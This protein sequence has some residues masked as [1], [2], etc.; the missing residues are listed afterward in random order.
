MPKKDHRVELTDTKV[1]ALKPAPKGSRYQVMD[2]LVPGFGLRITDTGA[3]TFILRT[4][5]PGG[6][7]TASRR[8]I[9]RVGVMTLADARDKARAWQALV[10]RGIDPSLEEEKQRA[11]EVEKRAN[12][13][14][15][16]AEDFIAEKLPSER[17]RVD[18]ERDI[19]RELLPK[20]AKF[21]IAEISDAM[22]V[23]LVKAKART[24]KVAAR[25]MLALIRRMFRWAI[26][27][28]VYG[29]K[30][31]P[32][33]GVRASDIIGEVV[34]VRD[35]V[36]DDAEL[37]ALYEATG[38]IGY[39]AGAVY[40]LLIVT[41]L[42]LREVS[43]AEWKEFDFDRGVWTIPAQRMKGK[44][45]GAKKARAHEVP[46]TAEVRAVL[47]DVP[48]F[49]KPKGDFVFSTTGGVR[50]VW[51]GAKVKADIDARMLAKLGNKAFAA[52]WVNHDIRRTVR[53]HLSA[54]KISENA[55]EAVLAHVRPGIAAVY[56]HHGYFA[57]KKEALE[58]W[59]AR[60][61][62]I[63][64]PSDAKIVQLSASR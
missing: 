57:E 27:Q 64:D 55:R 16:V 35:R 58:L 5:Y 21:P 48:Q 13:F 20:W 34:S 53:S 41:G 18:V 1:R 51:I 24:G 62:S 46:L 25:N 63:V 47:D 33:D 12:T 31:S 59:A 56:D 42:R 61:R 44:D 40:R 29:I 7:A 39:P 36:L 2:S 60:L 15:A 32:A 14:G 22:V 11:A 3:K 43:E 37:R 45:G 26:A 4:R 6:G 54:L 8:E 10:A 52:R 50:P 30:S 49:E 38:E 28:R 19:R 17:S 9:G 23:G